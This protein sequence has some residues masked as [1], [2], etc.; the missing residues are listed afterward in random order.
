MDQFIRPERDAE[1]G[2]EPQVPRGCD[3][4]RGRQI[5]HRTTAAKREP[6]ERRARGADVVEQ[7]DRERRA[8]LQRGRRGEHDADRDGP[9]PAH[10]R[11][12][13]FACV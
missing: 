8:D 10:R 6:Q 1:R 13:T 11:P 12:L 9:L 7:R 2:G 5:A 3:R 4:S